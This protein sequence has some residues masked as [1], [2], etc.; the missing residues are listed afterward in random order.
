MS[1]ATGTRDIEDRSDCERLVRAFYGKA[2]VD[3]M[4]GW[5]FVDVARLDVENHVPRIAS[6]W[7]TILLGS[8]TYYGS[9]FAPHQALNKKVRLRPGHFERWLALWRATVDELFAGYLAEAAKAHAGRVAHAFEDR[10][11]VTPG[12]TGPPAALGGPT[13]TITQHGPD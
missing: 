8:Q 3:P 2:L 7:E 12:P 5:I 6:F 1:T 4:I 13:L 9:S 10:L 11:R